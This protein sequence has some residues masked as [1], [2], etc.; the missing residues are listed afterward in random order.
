MIVKEQGGSIHSVGEAA[1]TL[2]YTCFYATKSYME[3]NPV[4]IEKF[5]RAIYKGQLWVSKNKDEDVVKAIKSFF[6]DT[7]EALMIQVVKNYKQI[8]AYSKTP[9]LQKADMTRLMDIVQSYD[10][11]LLKERPPYEK[12]VDNKFGEKVVKEVK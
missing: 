6:P 12:V 8:D 1:G 4:I 10:P 2:P 7:D 11:E 9:I 3:K 5:T